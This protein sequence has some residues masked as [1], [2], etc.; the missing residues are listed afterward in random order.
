MNDDIQLI[1]LGQLIGEAIDPSCLSFE[2]SIEETDKGFE[3]NSSIES[4]NKLSKSDLLSHGV[5]DFGGR[6][7][8]P[9]FL[10]TYIQTDPDYKIISIDIEA[11]A[12]YGIGHGPPISADVSKDDEAQVAKEIA[13]FLNTPKQT[14][15]LLVDDTNWIKQNLPR[16][17]EISQNAVF[18]EEASKKYIGRI[19]DPDLAKENGWDVEE[20][21]KS[22]FGYVKLITD[23]EHH[24]FFLGIQLK[25]DKKMKITKLKCVL[26]ENKPLTRNKIIY[27]HKHNMVDG[28]NFERITRILD[29]IG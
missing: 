11:Y 19:I 16:F 14:D 6:P 20:N 9:V 21:L 23:C 15:G 17:D 12:S 26:S 7:G 8:M 13:R 5:L 4:L 22:C 10:S 18:F 2:W 27:Q 1:E 25:L 3:I 24:V 28:F 29:V